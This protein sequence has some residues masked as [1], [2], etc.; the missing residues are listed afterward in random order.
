MSTDFPPHAVCMKSLK[1]RPFVDPEHF[2]I[3]E[4]NFFV[5]F[6]KYLIFNLDEHAKFD[7]CLLQIVKNICVYFICLVSCD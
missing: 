3:K 6:G 2:R 5:F 4:T 7:S 1:F